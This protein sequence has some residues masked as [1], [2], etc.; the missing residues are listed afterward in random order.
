MAKVSNC[1]NYTADTPRLLKGKNIE[2]K[3]TCPGMAEKGSLCLDHFSKVQGIVNANENVGEEST[4]S[5]LQPRTQA[6]K[7]EEES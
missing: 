5:Q 3:D 1:P 4:K 2:R 7:K 6:Q